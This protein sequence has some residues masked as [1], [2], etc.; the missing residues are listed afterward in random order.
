M[1]QRNS[2]MEESSKDGNYKEMHETQKQQS[3][4]RFQQHSNQRH[5]RFFPLMGD[6]FYNCELCGVRISVLQ[7]VTGTVNGQEQFKVCSVCLKE[8]H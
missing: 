8:I 3:P 5:S 6:N 4:P 1:R 7:I 2:P